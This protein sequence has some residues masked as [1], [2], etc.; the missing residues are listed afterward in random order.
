MQHSSKPRNPKL[1]GPVLLAL[2]VVVVWAVSGVLIYIYAGE[3]RG[4]FGDMF[5]AINALFSGLAFAGVLYA[6]LLQRTDLKLQR[7]EFELSR[8]EMAAQR[9][10]LVLQNATL[11]LQSFENTFFQLLRLHNDI[12]NSI[13]LVREGTGEVTTRG[14]DCFRVFYTSFRVRWLEQRT[15]DAGSDEPERI[16]RTYLNFNAEV[17]PEAGHYFLTL[18]NILKYVDRSGV[19]DKKHYTNLVRAQLSSYEVVLLFYSCLSERGTAKFKP[20]VERYALLKMLPRDELLD[21]GHVALYDPTAFGSGPAP[22]A[23]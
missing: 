7:H 15:Q 5:G 4:L 14:R 3:G 8:A 18:Y 19:A 21:P 11:R 22:A 10:Q 17:E 23:Y 13:D 9:E 20:I 2:L 12:V 16:R 6:I 1:T